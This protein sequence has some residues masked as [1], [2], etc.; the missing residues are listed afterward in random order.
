[1]YDKR[2]TQEVAACRRLVRNAIAKGYLVSV[3]DGEEWACKRSTDLA[4]IMDALG[5]TDEDTI[6]LRCTDGTKV[7]SIYLV[8][9]NAE[10]GSE[11]VADYTDNDAI[12]ELT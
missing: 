7:G 3:H 5:N 4:T 6:Q 11:L 8:W 2:P 1:M 9:G 12:G 10:D